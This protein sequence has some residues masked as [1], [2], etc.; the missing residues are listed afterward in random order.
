VG[1]EASAVTTK[2]E[3]SKAFAK[4]MAG[5]IKVL[6]PKPVEPAAE[7]ESSGIHTDKATKPAP[8][9]SKKLDKQVWPETQDKADYI[10]A[11]LEGDVNPDHVSHERLANE[12]ANILT[13]SAAQLDA[14]VGSLV[15]FVASKVKEVNIL[16]VIKNNYHTD[17]RFTQVIENPKQFKNFRYENGLLYI[18]HRDGRKALC[19]PGKVGFKGQT[20]REIIISEAHSLLAHLGSSKTYHYLHDH[21]WW[22]N[23]TAQVQAF[24]ASCSTCA[25]TKVNN[26][27]PYG[28]LESL[29]VPQYPWEAMGI[30][31]VGPLPES[32]N[33][34]GTFNSLTV[35]I[36]LLS[37]MVHL[38]PS[39]TNY[40]AKQTAELV[41]AEVYKY[42]GLP[43]YIVSDRDVLFT[44]NF[45][46]ELN[47]LVG[48]KMKMSSAYHPQTDG[49]TERANRTIG[50]MLRAM[51]GPDQRDWVQKLPA[52]EF[53]IN[54][55]RSDSTG[56]SPFLLNTGRV[57]RSMIWNSE[58]DQ[59]Y[60]GVRKFAEAI[61]I[62]VMSAHDSIL[63]ARVKQT[64][65]ANR[66]RHPSPFQEG[67]LVY[68]STK[69]M[70]IPKGLAR[71]LNLK[72][73]GPYKITKDFNNNTYRIELPA[74]LKKRGLHPD[75]HSSLLRVHVP[76]D[77]RLFPGRS[78]TQ[79]GLTENPKT[80][81][82]ANR[83]VSH[84]G[85]G[86][87]ATF[88]IEWLAGDRT[89]LP[90]DEA[91]KFNV[92]QDYLDICGVDSAS[93][94]Q[95]GGAMNDDALALFLGGVSIIEA[96]QEAEEKRG[97][98]KEKRG[99]RKMVKRD[100]GGRRKNQP[101]EPCS[102][103]ASYPIEYY[104]DELPPRLIPSTSTT[105]SNTRSPQ[106]LETSLKTALKFTIFNRPANMPFQLAELVHMVR[107]SP[108]LIVINRD[109]TPESFDRGQITRIVQHEAILRSGEIPANYAAPHGRNVVADAWNG[110][111]NVD[112]AFG[113]YNKK[114]K[115][116]WIE[117]T[118]APS[119]D[120]I[121]GP[122]KVKMP[123][124]ST[125]NPNANTNDPLGIMRDAERY[126]M[127]A[128][129]L[130]DEVTTMKKRK[131]MNGIRAA[132]RKAKKEK[133]NEWGL[134]ETKKVALGAPEASAWDPAADRMDTSSSAMA[135]DKTPS[136]SAASQSNSTKN[137]KEGDKARKATTGAGSSK[138]KD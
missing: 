129:L 43:K 69:N 131:R 128:G 86:A 9:K 53:A 57:P 137:A 114:G 72:Y 14:P 5:K 2:A 117:G 48:I 116:G 84:V 45:W 36:D 109:G 35:V 94:L 7:G 44:S 87:S 124:N 92:F 85:K 75:F 33:R 60:P 82:T 13:G 34:D 83:V 63:E 104:V 42:H 12:R 8:K 28:L 98:K 132:E 77:D 21:V 49:A 68:V 89:W 111:S 103:T 78:E 29:D 134:G 120:E 138:T 6:P 50:Q 79:V 11:I 52:I 70:S 59:K 102:R 22:G 99:R 30:D 27:K 16:N 25:R 66:R 41:F 130:M 18:I 62:A 19:V 112:S 10:R 100:G 115:F 106:D 81:W 23:M 105:R 3:S 133:Y 107:V 119:V 1:L 17:K 113:M 40:T 90:L 47:K 39:R 61:K 95:D 80:E 73:I 125:A 74:D 24:C 101:V 122:E 56:F 32:K 64:R 76:N 108:N 46:K 20:I 15:N 4:R 118:A 127:M 37:R 93:E 136:T 58:T 54:L 110:E 65:D 121:M 51:I 67:D 135:I 71:K 55:A 88:E 126:D 123:K 26:Q 97:G 31:F 96:S 38:I 91:S